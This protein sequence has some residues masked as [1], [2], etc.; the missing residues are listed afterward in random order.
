MN[1]QQSEFSMATPLVKKSASD[2]SLIF[3]KKADG[4]SY[5]KFLHVWRNLHY[6]MAYLFDFD[7]YVQNSKL[8]VQPQNMAS[9]YDGVV[10]VWFDTPE[11]KSSTYASPFWNV[12]SRQEPMMLKQ[13][14]MS[15]LNVDEYVVLNGPIEKGQ[16]HSKLIIASE[17]KSQVSHDELKEYWLSQHAFDVIALMVENEG[18]V[19]Y[20]ISTVNGLNDQN[21]NADS[22]GNYSVV[23]EL[24]FKDMSM[25]KQALN[26]KEW[27]AQKQASG[28]YIERQD[29]IVS[30]EFIGILPSNYK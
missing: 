29:E 25:L 17:K 5:D 2:K 7:G 13:E 26:S 12:I 9:P 11:A 19:R 6:P 10:G 20:T 3:F 22:E 28:H 8:P 21:N 23:E 16:L 4:I 27:F 24:W 30:E 15:V 1:E 18:L 14:S